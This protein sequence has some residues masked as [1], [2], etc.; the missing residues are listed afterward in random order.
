MACRKRLNRPANGGHAADRLY[1]Q[2]VLKQ[3]KSLSDSLF[4]NPALVKDFYRP[5]L[6]LDRTELVQA[7]L[8]H[9]SVV[10]QLAAAMQETEGVRTAVPSAQ[11][12]A[13]GEQAVA[14]NHHPSRSGD[15]YVYQEPH[16]YLMD[17]GMAAM[18]GS[19]WRYDQ[20]VPLIFVGPGIPSGAHHA[21]VHPIDVAP[22]PGSPASHSGTSRRRRRI[23]ASLPAVVCRQPVRLLT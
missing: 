12:G 11:A 22:H 5:Y 16:W 9:H 21:L 23:P 4:G 10:S 18:H 6:Y 14:Y 17:P 3:A 8:D 7:E 1:V 19:P 13:L 2:D 20:Q 15:I